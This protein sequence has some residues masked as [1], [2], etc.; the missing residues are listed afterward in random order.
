MKLI[1]DT[2]EVIV[3]GNINMTNAV[4][5]GYNA[6]KAWCE[7][8]NLHNRL[9]WEVIAETIKSVIGWRL[10]YICHKTIRFRYETAQ[11]LKNSETQK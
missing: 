2:T 8:P 4:E 7:N 3:N 11:E 6:Y 5:Q 10:W 1:T 9:M